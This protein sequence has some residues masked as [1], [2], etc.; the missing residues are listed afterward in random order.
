MLRGWPPITHVLVFS[1][2]PILSRCSAFD[3]RMP[4]L[5]ES[6]RP[7]SRIDDP[8]AHHAIRRA[9]YYGAHMYSMHI[10]KHLFLLEALNETTGRNHAYPVPNRPLG[11]VRLC[12]RFQFARQGG[13][14]KRGV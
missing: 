12:Q 8:R 7:C 1:P 13:A 2:C 6:S 3:D 4:Q 5:G 11:I 14:N 9:T 10:T